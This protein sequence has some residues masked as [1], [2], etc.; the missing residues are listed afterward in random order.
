[1][2]SCLLRLNQFAYVSEVLRVRVTF[3]YFSEADEI[4]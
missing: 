1:M 4:D 3:S 2:F